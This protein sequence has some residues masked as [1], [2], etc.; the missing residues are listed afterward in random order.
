MGFGGGCLPTDRLSNA[1]SACK[2]ISDLGFSLGRTG[3]FLYE[4]KD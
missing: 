1:G 4:F 2:D 3:I